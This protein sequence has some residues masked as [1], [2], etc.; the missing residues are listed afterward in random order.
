MKRRKRLVRINVGGF[1]LGST[2]YVCDFF[3]FSEDLT[4]SLAEAFQTKEFKICNE[5]HL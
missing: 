1:L 4:K 2:I 5:I 3:P